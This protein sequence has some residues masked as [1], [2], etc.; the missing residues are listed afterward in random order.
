MSVWRVVLSSA[1]GCARTAPRRDSRFLASGE[2]LGGIAL[3]DR[4]CRLASFLE[5]AKGRRALMAAKMLPHVG[6]TR[7]E[8]RHDR[9]ARGCGA[10]LHFIGDGGEKRAKFGIRLCYFR[11][12]SVKPFGEATG[13]HR[14]PLCGFSISA[15]ERSAAKSGLARRT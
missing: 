13:V 3:D 10:I 15:R 11:P 2:F 14:R 12:E 5:R 8:V 6:D 1:A 7:A 4:E 9:P